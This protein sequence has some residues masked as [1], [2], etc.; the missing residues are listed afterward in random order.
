M[1]TSVLAVLVGSVMLVR[2][3]QGQ[4]PAPANPLDG[5]PDKMPFDVPYGRRSRWTA[6][7]R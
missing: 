1:R 6:R 2:A 5:I 7:K 4:V 3:A